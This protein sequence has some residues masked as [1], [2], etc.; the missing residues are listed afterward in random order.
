MYPSGVLVLHPSRPVSDS[1]S[2]PFSSIQSS[3]TR[4]N[5]LAR[6]ESRLDYSD[7]GG[8]GEGTVDGGST[9]Y[10]RALLITSLSFCVK[11]SPCSFDDLSWPW[12]GSKP[13]RIAPCVAARARDSTPVPSR[14]V[15]LLL[16]V[17]VWID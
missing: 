12:D 5:F 9:G 10:D 6:I 7:A 13:S 1:E 2:I 17:S 4:P 15:C 8:D 14:F 3:S 11:P 16:P